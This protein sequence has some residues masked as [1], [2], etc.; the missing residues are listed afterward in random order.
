VHHSRFAHGGLARIRANVIES[1]KRLCSLQEKLQDVL[2][3]NSDIDDA[4]DHLTQIIE[5]PSTNIERS[6]LKLSLQRVVKS[7]SFIESIEFVFKIFSYHRL[8][9]YLTIQIKILMH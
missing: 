6:V 4:L 2:I 9:L 7:V 3:I 1:N 5:S 8:Y